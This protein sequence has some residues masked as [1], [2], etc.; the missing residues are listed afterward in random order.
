MDKKSILIIVLI[1]LYFWWT[2]RGKYVYGGSEEIHPDKWF[3]CFEE[4]CLESYNKMEQSKVDWFTFSSGLSIQ[5]SQNDTDFS[6]KINEYLKSV[7]NFLICL[8]EMD[9]INP[10][11]ELDPN[12]GSQFP[13]VVNSK[14]SSSYDPIIRYDPYQVIADWMPDGQYYE[15]YIY[16]TDNWIFD[17]AN[18]QG[19]GARG[20]IFD[21]NKVSWN[22]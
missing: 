11:P 21:F 10:Q 4:K 5:S 17:S 2:R 12:A 8:Y 14:I 22:C 16:Q 18:E 19:L 6:V 20:V 7:H 13:H 15:P 3:L 9:N 1:F